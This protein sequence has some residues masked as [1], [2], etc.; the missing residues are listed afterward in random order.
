MSTPQDPLNFFTLEASECIERLDAAL[1]GAGSGGTGLAPDEFVRAARTLRGAATMHRLGG[2]SDL[3]AAVERA[4]RALRAGELQ[5]STSLHAALV[6]TVDDLKI[7]LHKVRSWGP[8]EDARTAR[9][10]A[11]LARYVPA[12]AGMASAAPLDASAGGGLQ[13]G[14]STVTSAGGASADAYF[15][16]ETGEIATALDVFVERPAARG[17]LAGALARVRTLRGVAALTDRP[18]LPETLDAIERAGR[19]LEFEPTRDTQPALALLAAAALLLRRASG[20]LRVGG[21]RSVLGTAEYHRFAL[22]RAAAEEESEVAD[23]IVPVDELFYDDGTAGLTEAAPNPPTTP[24]E[25][26]RL[27]V[28]S[29]AEHLRVLIAAAREAGAREAGGREGGTVAVDRA[30]AELRSALR[31][32]RNAARSFGE[33]RVA[34]FVTPFADG[35]VAFDFL[36]LTAL[37]EAAALLADP[38]AGAP[39]LPDHFSGIGQP[40]GIDAEIGIGMS[41]IDEVPAGLTSTGP[42]LAETLGWAQAAPDD[43]LETEVVAVEPPAAAGRPRVLTPTGRELQAFLQDGIIGISHLMDEPLIDEPI[44]EPQRAPATA[45][46]HAARAAH[47]NGSAATSGEPDIVP[48]ESLLYRGPAALERARLLR[49]MLRTSGSSPESLAE[50]FDLLDLAATS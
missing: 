48:I 12:T 22:A 5:W 25:R 33:Q 16:A 27:E 23:E 38:G 44:R 46:A 30:A 26:F 20:E 8:A 13:G 21:T 14:G 47:A 37:D 50:L 39:A 18:P 4:G 10:I 9:R 45:S 7:L 28:V 35:N 41:R 3:T 6:A 24:A 2:I 11:D 15:A 49:D 29:Q 42:S 34:E 32:V 17:T 31:A 40:E 19:V 36:A 43:T 1:H